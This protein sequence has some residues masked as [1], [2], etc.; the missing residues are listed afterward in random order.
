MQ[1]NKMSIIKANKGLQIE[2]GNYLK[3]SYLRVRT[4]AAKNKATKFADPEIENIVNQYL[5][6][7]TS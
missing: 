3:V 6:A 7:K 5:K 2:I 4:W 1:T